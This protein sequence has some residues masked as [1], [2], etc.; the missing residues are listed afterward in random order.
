[1]DVSVN[2]TVT[3]HWQ[4]SD[5]PRNVWAPNLQPDVVDAIVL[6]YNFSARLKAILRTTPPSD[7]S[8]APAKT[9]TTDKEFDSHSLADVERAVPTRLSI[10]LKAAKPNSRNFFDIAANFTSYQSIDIGEKCKCS[11]CLGSLLSK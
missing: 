7:S 6:R 11:P 8:E 5:L 1:M 10:A 4:K 3:P 9:Y 2:H